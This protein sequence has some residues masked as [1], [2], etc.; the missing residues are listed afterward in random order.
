MS[1]CSRCGSVHGLAGNCNCSDGISFP[2]YS[3]PQGYGGP[4]GF[5]GFQ[6]SQGSQGFQGV[7]YQGAQ[8]NQG[9]GSAYMTIDQ[10]VVVV[11]ANS[12]GTVTSWVGAYAD[13]RLY[14]NEEEQDI[15]A[16][17]L[18]ITPASGANLAYTQAPSGGYARR[19]TFTGMSTAYNVRTV[20]IGLTLGNNDYKIACAVVK[21]I[22]GPN[23]AQGFQGPTGGIGPTGYTGIQG[24]QGPTAIGPQGLQG[25][26]GPGTSFLNY[27]VTLTYT[28]LTTSISSGYDLIDAPAEAYKFHSLYE[29]V[30]KNYVSGS[31]FV[32]ATLNFRFGGEVRDIMSLDEDFVNAT[33]NQVDILMAAG[34][35]YDAKS[36]KIAVIADRNF[37]GG[38]ANSK[39]VLDF[40]YRTVDFGS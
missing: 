14:L 4:Q 16:L 9:Y 2:F 8:G 11:P 12:A 38:S 39:I 31:P 34:S 40:V 33:S 15:S 22:T 36:A 10:P 37:T 32:G 7:G 26:I 5:Q 25:S 19:V 23:G 30:A 29:V 18:D 1:T 27:Q 3:G 24:F 35:Y 21:Q 20:L 17:V 28:I 13:V 6:G